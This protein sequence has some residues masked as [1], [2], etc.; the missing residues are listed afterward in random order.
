[1]NDNYRRQIFLRSKSIG[2]IHSAAAE[3]LARYDKGRDTRTYLEVDVD[4]LSM[5]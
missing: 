3:I 4:P 2:E 1:M 5:L